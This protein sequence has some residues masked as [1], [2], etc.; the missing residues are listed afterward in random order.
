MTTRCALQRKQ[1][2]KENNMAAF[3]RLRLRG[4]Q[5]RTEPAHPAARFDHQQRRL[6]AAGRILRLYFQVKIVTSNPVLVAN[7]A[8]AAEEL[9]K[10]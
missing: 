10:E 1:N 3:V 9:A 8:H 4:C 6:L 2:H 7:F 5:H